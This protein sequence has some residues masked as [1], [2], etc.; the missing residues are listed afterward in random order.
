MLATI[1]NTVGYETVPLDDVTKR[2]IAAAAI[3][4][5]IHYEI[6]TSKAVGA[7]PATKK[8]WVPNEV[9]ASRENFLTTLVVGGGRHAARGRGLR[10]RQGG[11]EGRQV[12]R[13]RRGVAAH[14]GSRLPGGQHA[15]ACLE[16]GPSVPEGAH[17]TS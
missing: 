8:I 13:V 9:F 15:Q 4:E 12:L 1:V 16:E 14:A 17:V 5:K 3:E 10:L 6:L 11:L 7:T 2:N